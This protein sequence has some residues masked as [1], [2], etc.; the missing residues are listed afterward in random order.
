MFRLSAKALVVVDARALHSH[1]VLTHL[2]TVS[3]VLQFLQESK[4]CATLYN[5]I[6][7]TICYLRDA[8][9]LRIHGY[10]MNGC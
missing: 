10:G 8:V 2:K 7:F 3:T 9:A 6:E 5:C 1:V 4:T